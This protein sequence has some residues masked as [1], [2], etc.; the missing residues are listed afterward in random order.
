MD[1]LFAHPAFHG[2]LAPFG[3]GLIVAVALQRFRLAGLSILA[4]FVTCMYFV[5]G[6]QITPLTATRKVMLVG[7]FAAAAGVAW[8]SAFRPPRYAA[9][10]ALVAAASA[11]WAFWSV[12]MQKPAQDAWLLG[13]SAAL[14][15]GFLV[16]S[17]QRWLAEDAVRAGAAALG[18][19]L[20]LGV[21]AIFSASATYGLYGI[22]IGAGAGAFLLPQMIVG[23][24]WLAGSTFVLPAM[25]LSGLIGAGAMILAQLPWYSLLLFGLVPLAARGPGFRASP[26]WLQAT[27]FSI[28]CFVIAALACILA[29][30]AAQTT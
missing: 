28:Y 7:V 6:L 18:L 23:R 17:S 2:G 12:L 25:L 4:A 20:G 11:V 8:D 27:V 13:G 19:G 10:V 16:W 1:D 3:I 14:T 15:V 21:A 5:S 22:A 30:P 9:L 29:W 26:V 24:K